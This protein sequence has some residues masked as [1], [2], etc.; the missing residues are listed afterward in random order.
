LLLEFHDGQYVRIP[1]G[2]QLPNL[3]ELTPAGSSKAPGIRPG[4]A[5][6]KEASPPSPPL[7]RAVLLFRDGHK[8]EIDRYV[9]ENDVIYAGSDYWSTGS[10]TKKIPISQLDVPATLKLNQQRGGKFSLPS[11]PGE[12]AV[13]F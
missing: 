1:T 12:I 6:Q 4:V 3:P 5:S 7:P 13:R 10:W 2:G 8:E 11:G 9:I